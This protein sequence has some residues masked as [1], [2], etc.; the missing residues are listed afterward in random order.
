MPLPV[1]VGT[2]ATFR[3]QICLI[4]NL[5]RMLW[6]HTFQDK[7][8]NIRIFTV[9]ELSKNALDRPRCPSLKVPLPM[10]GWPQESVFLARFSPFLCGMPWSHWSWLLSSKS[11]QVGTISRSS[12]VYFLMEM[13]DFLF[14]LTLPFIAILLKRSCP[15]Q[16]SP[17]PG[18]AIIW[19]VK[20]EIGS[21]HEL[22]RCLR[23]HSPRWPLPLRE[24]PVMF[25]IW[26]TKSLLP[27]PFYFAVSTYSCEWEQAGEEI[28][29]D[30]GE[31]FYLNRWKAFV[32]WE[33]CGI[34]WVAWKAE[35][36]QCWNSSIRTLWPASKGAGEPIFVG[37]KVAGE[38]AS[39]I[40]E[41]CLQS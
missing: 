9:H 10:P 39:D 23:V 41:V 22:Y 3:E 38:V 40:L 19:R 8:Q 17:V 13:V 16:S 7:R 15:S 34:V 24:E 30:G 4:R 26:I 32:Q 6:E 12:G 31:K 14:P 35:V 5:L 33:V 25:Y 21:C 11:S 37:V 20:E 36:S 27:S 29:E 28:Q 2:L 1:M 18:D